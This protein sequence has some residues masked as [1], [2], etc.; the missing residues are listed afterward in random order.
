MT[1]Y[2]TWVTHNLWELS[3]QDR[4]VGSCGGGW[5]VCV[6]GWDGEEKKEKALHYN[7]HFLFGSV[8]Y[9][10][11]KNW[12]FEDFFF[13]LKRTT[14]WKCCFLHMSTSHIV[15]LYSSNPSTAQIWNGEEHGATGDRSVTNSDTGIEGGNLK[16]KANDSIWKNV[17]TPLEMVW[18]VCKAPFLSPRLGRGRLQT[19]GKIGHCS[20]LG[21]SPGGYSQSDGCSEIFH[22][23]QND[24]M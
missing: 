3:L 7:L 10:W 4:G 20:Q 16:G 21:T 11:N 8:L 1:I 14:F 22:R 23:S 5:D 2:R 15:W 13:F 17:C 19:S 9:F 6:W 12:Y 24:Q 18:I